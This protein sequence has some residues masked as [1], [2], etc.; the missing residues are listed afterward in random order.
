MPRFRRT[1]KFSEHR[2]FKTE[3]M[4]SILTKQ[5]LQDNDDKF[6]EQFI[7]TN[8][9]GPTVLENISVPVSEDALK[10]L[11]KASRDFFWS[12]AKK[13]NGVA[14]VKGRTII[15]LDD[16]TVGITIDR[17]GFHQIVQTEW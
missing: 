7:T 4:N 9:S 15:D 2:N 10:E 14:L 8:W 5:N 6:L 17:H 12:L 1:P 3:E 16:V 13:S 11:L